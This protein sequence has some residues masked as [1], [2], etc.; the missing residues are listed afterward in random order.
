MKTLL[1]FFL[2]ITL[3]SLT[4]AQTTAIPDANFEQALINLGLDIAPINGSIPTAIINTVSSLNVSNKN[5]TNLT[6]IEDFTSLTTLN[7]QTNQ[8]TNLDITQN[9][10]LTDLDCGV[11]QLTSIDISQNT[12]L[13]WLSCYNNLL[14]SLNVIQ[15]TNLVYLFC[16]SNQLTSLNI[17]QNIS[18]NVLYCSDNQLIEIDVSQNPTLINFW[19]NDN[20]LTCLNVKNG[21]NSN[22]TGF[23]AYNNPNLNCIEVDNVT[24]SN[25]NWSLIDIGASFS[26]NCTN[27]CALGIEENNISISS[28]YPNP[29]TGNFTIDLG[30]VKQDIKAT[31]TNSLGQVILTE[32]YTSTNYINIDIEGSKG[33]YFLQLESNGEVTT[34]KIIKE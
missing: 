5:I 16:H 7:C 17:I 15:N 34:K 25:T 27:P 23:Q 20:L 14:S 21:N 33:I 10:A 22:F 24:Y 13:T 30:K 29:T 6:G 4:I 26:T 18:L 19:C 8:L 1:S 12:A 31:L 32:N 11:N 3:S 9:T 2:L 28:V